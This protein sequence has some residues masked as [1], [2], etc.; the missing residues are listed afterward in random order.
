MIDQSFDFLYGGSNSSQN[1]M[2][3]IQVTKILWIIRIHWHMNITHVSKIRWLARLDWYFPHKS[4][5]LKTLT[6]A[7]LLF[8]FF[9]V[10]VTWLLHSQ[11][12]HNHCL[13][14][15]KTMAQMTSTTIDGATSIAI[16]TKGKKSSIFCHCNHSWY[17]TSQLNYQTAQNMN[18]DIDFVQGDWFRSKVHSNLGHVNK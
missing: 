1:V 12:Y 6:Q 11:Y 5:Y 17:Q 3:R 7:T 15:T 4:T 14:I 10:E 9:E 16:P 2:V 13:Y 8:H 18:D